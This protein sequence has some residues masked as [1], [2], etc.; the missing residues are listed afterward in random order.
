MYQMSVIGSTGQLLFDIGLLCLIGFVAMDFLFRILL[1]RAGHKRAFLRGF[2][3]YSEYLRMKK[4]YGWSAWPVY[5][6][7]ATLGL[8]IVLVIVAVSKYGLLP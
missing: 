5:V 2:M 1:N 4:R 7:W 8:G 3:S 6:M